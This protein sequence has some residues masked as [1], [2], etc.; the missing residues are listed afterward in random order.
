MNQAN[1][2]MEAD[3]S[4]AFMDHVAPPGSAFNKV[5][6]AELGMMPDHVSYA[7]KVHLGLRTIKPFLVQFSRTEDRFIASVADIEEYGVGGT[8]SEALDDLGHTLAELYFS[9]ER[10]AAR[11]SGDLQTVF[12]TLQTHLSPAAR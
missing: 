3:F 9:L 10:D 8:R 7:A 4:G 5:V 11:L 6:F 2:I 1:A 12:R